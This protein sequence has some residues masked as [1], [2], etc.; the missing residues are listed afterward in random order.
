MDE[1]GLMLYLEW[2]VNSGLRLAQHFVQRAAMR[3]GVPV[4]PLSGNDIERLKLYSW[5]GNVRELGAVLERAVLLGHGHYLDLDAALGV[6]LVKRPPDPA[7]PPERPAPN[8][9]RLEPLD[10]VIIAHLKRAL[11]N[12]HG[13]VDGPNGAA[14]QLAVNPNTFRAKLRKY[15]I[16]PA[17]YRS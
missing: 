4:P 15:K 9:E 5:P 11:A 12:T 16:D 17:A 3:L 10:A 8:R 1:R 6:Q 14:K 7:P 2:Q 13:R